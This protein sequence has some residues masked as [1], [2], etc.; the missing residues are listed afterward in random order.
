M[1]LMKKRKRYYLQNQ[2]FYELAYDEVNNYLYASETDYS[3]YGKVHI[4]DADN[5]LV[6]EFDCGTLDGNLY[7][8]GYMEKDWISSENWGSKKTWIE[9]IGN[10]T[11]LLR[12]Y[13]NKRYG[14]NVYSLNPFLNFEL[15]GHKYERL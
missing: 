9:T 10:D 14:C 11:E 13:L 1:L 4:Y 2:N 6:S 3:T 5:N 12:D 15:E 7:Y 8:D